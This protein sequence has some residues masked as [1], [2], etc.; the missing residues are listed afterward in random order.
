M[1]TMNELRAL[2]QARDQQLGTVEQRLHDLRSV[3]GRPHMH[4]QI[5]SWATHMQTILQI[6]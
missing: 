5:A 3:R 6:A 1:D 4:L 2:V